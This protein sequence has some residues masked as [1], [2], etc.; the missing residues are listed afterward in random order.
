MLQHFA[1]SRSWRSTKGVGVLAVSAL[2]IGIGAAT[3]I[4]TVIDAL[5]LKPVPFDH[6]ERFVS[7]LGA[8]LD[9]PKGMS[10]ITLK[11]ALEYQEQ[12]RSFDLFGCFVFADYNL[13]APGEPQH[14]NGVEV[15][16]SLVNGLAVNPIIG[17]WFQQA[18]AP[19]AVLSHSLW[20]RLGSDPNIAGKTVTLNGHSYTVG[21][22]MPP[23]FNLPLAGPYSEAQM[24]IWLPLDMLRP[25]E[26]PG[27][28]N[29][30]CYARLRPGVTLREASAE[31]KREAAEIAR[32]EPASHPGYTARVDNLHELVRRNIRPILLL[33]FDAA[34][35]L[36]LITCANVGGLLVARS[37]ARARET[38]VRVALGAGLRQLAAQYAME[39]LFVA[40]LGAALGLILSFI[41][42]RVLIA[43]GGTESSRIAGISIGWHVVVFALATAV[44]AG[45]LSSMAP[46]WQAARMQPNDVL[47]E[48]VRAS[49]GAR[50]RRLSRWLVVGEIVLACVLLSLSTVLAGELYRL[51][52]VS[53][54]FDPDHLLT[55]QITV[56]PDTIPGKP[57]RVVYQDRL[58]RALEAIPGV[59]GVGIINQ[60]PLDGCCFT[61]TIYPE[62]AAADPQAPDRIN[63]LVV[64][65]GYFRT[66]RIPLRRG[67]FLQDRDRTGDPLPVLIDQSAAKRYWP[68]RDPV[69]QIGH[70]GNPRGSP[71]QVLG[72]AG[73]VKNNGLD[74]DTVP[75]IYLPAAVVDVNPLN[76]IVR[77]PIPAKALVPEVLRAVQGVNPAQPIHSVRT[78]N[79]IVR[80]SLALKRAASYVITFFAF[81]ALVMAT[82]GA[83][84]VVSYSVRQRRVEMG[85]RMALGAL[86]RDLL[87]LVVGSGMKMAA[88]G[89]AIGAVASVAATWFLVR[90]FEINV[91]NGGSGRLEN[92]GVL[93]FL[94]SASLVGMVALVSSF[95]PAWWASLLSPMVAIR[96]EPG[97]PRIPH[98]R[99]ASRAGA[100]IAPDGTLVTELIEASR[101]AAS[102][103][104]ALSAALEALRSIMGANSAVLLEQTDGSGE[105]E[106]TIAAPVGAVKCSIPVRGLLLGRLRSYAAPLPISA[107][108]LDTWY[109]WATEVAPAH[110]KEIEM[111][112]SGGTRLAVAL[113]TNKELLGLVLLGGRANDELYAPEQVRMLRAS[114]DQF[115]VLVENARLTGRVL[116]QEKLRRDLAL[117]A[118]VQR[119]LLARQSLENAFVSVAAFSIP[120]RSVGGDYFD[121]LE[122]NDGRTGIAMADVA[123]KGV[124][125]ALIMSAVQ[126]LVR[127]FSADPEAT[128]PELAAKMNHFL[129]RSTGPSSYATFFYAQVDPRE[130]KLRYV[131]AGHNP[132]YLLRPNSG[133]VQIEELATGGTVVGM[134]PKAQY[135]EGVVDLHPGDVLVMFTDGVPEAQN[136]QEE[137]FGEERLKS[138]VTGMVCRR[139]DE[140]VSRLGRELKDWIRD[141]PQYDDLTTVLMKVKS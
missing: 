9:D 117:A 55:F 13:T 8:S 36:L 16:P 44:L 40:F 69:G 56:A 83:Y 43:F 26:N 102:Y 110:L 2:A 51:M 109:R 11:D 81:A 88:S 75:E 29:T 22:V 6:G 77:S 37:V 107:E 61:T 68:N 131:N 46:L 111:L 137:E 118:E 24:D 87:A 105:F 21:G 90:N 136:P 121:L 74:N 108:D 141:A 71:F 123:G 119:R 103:R 113:R 85:T 127:V 140:I 70:F 76:L 84:G 45:V 1:L 97:T 31:V 58:V 62:G 132:P 52:R 23:G 99:T 138:A 79:D 15:S 135:Q 139:V 32:R 66:L 49:A 18:A 100:D 17:R 4:Y 80:G 112:R 78:V 98:A 33:L 133:S 30:F 95:F 25:A 3:A 122:L 82:I 92:P 67:R 94:L 65:A 54:G 134:F 20:V 91:G 114:A 120:A 7:V 125:A 116:E 28:A 101:R 129:Y 27:S 115:A 64:N 53:P 50:S 41:V 12:S 19:A 126:A 93:P 5:L 48:G 60:L 96:D 59:T 124:P 35:L 57:D 38:A 47:S 128:L 104:E 63:F 89:I 73:D 130:R 86:P 72:V 34:G 10:S 14:L 39:G 106:T 42:V